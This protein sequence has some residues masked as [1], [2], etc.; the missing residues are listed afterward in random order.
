MKEKYKIKKILVNS[1]LQEL[2]IH[3]AD[4][5]G[6]RYPLDPLR[7]V[8]PCVFCQ[9]GHEAMGAPVDPAVFAEAPTINRTISEIRMVGNY[10]LQIVWGDG[11]NTG[12][13][14]LEKLRSMCPVEHGVL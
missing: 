9:G 4:G 14:R 11:H 3:W 1:D 2:Q 7:K 10:A 8:C 12:I 6:S 13:Y 5:H